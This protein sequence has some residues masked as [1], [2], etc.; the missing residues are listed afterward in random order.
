MTYYLPFHD[1]WEIQ[2]KILNEEKNFF[3][4]INIIKNR[5]MRD[6]R[7]RESHKIIIIKKEKKRKMSE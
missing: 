5:E 6:I 3:F 4:I 1:S 7:K 2:Q